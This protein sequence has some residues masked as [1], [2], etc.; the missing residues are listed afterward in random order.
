[1]TGFEIV[2]VACLV[3]MCALL[4]GMVLFTARRGGG[5]GHAELE[6]LI[7]D[8]IKETERDRRAEASQVEERLRGEIATR[9]RETASVIGEVR[10]WIDR[11]FGEMALQERQNW[12]SLAKH[13]K[14]QDVALRGQVDSI[15]GLL[16][17]KLGAFVG[18]LEKY[19]LAIETGL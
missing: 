15:R 14:D 16:D 3:G 10:Q 18:D 19:K 4:G 7:G 8:F 9:A 5:V 11:K 2:V 17:Q 13:L 6:A 12:E 1:M